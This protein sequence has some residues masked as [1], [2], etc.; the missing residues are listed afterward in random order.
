MLASPPTAPDLPIT[1]SGCT[2]K[3][4]SLFKGPD[5]SA[6]TGLDKGCPE[7]LTA[8]RQAIRI[9]SKPLTSRGFYFLSELTPFLGPNHALLPCFLKASAKYGVCECDIGYR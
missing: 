4:F 7:T 6:L 8:I 5:I 1:S 2:G 3:E 9:D